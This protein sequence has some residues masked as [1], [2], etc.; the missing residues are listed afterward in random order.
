MHLSPTV[1]DEIIFLLIVSDIGGDNLILL[2]T[3]KRNKN[4]VLICKS[5]RKRYSDNCDTSSTIV[6][7]N[8]RDKEC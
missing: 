5:L 7:I 3:I 8:K 2:V 1:V 4:L 6:A